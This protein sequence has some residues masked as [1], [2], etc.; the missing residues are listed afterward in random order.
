MKIRLLVRDKRGMSVIVGYVLLI[1]LAIGM[2][3]AV[4][5]FL[6]FYVPKEQASCPESISL[7]VH[8]MSCEGNVF[9]IS[10]VNKGLFTV[11]GVFI[12]VGETGRTYKKLIN[13]P[14]PNSNS[15]ENCN[16]YFANGYLAS[17][18]KPGNSWSSS[19]PYTQGVGMREV[20]IEP[21]VVLKNS[22][23]VLC[24]R[25]VISRTIECT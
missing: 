25:A 3:A 11:D 18:L 17:P 23:R 21:L 5:S 13:C 2:A 22:T 14:D 7:I 12:K 10:L 16:I 19:F 15:I 4:Y 20:E 8:N 24:E 1:V 6:K 9:R